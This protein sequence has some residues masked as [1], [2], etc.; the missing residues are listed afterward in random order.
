LRAGLSVIHCETLVI[1]FGLVS[2][3]AEDTGS[4]GDL[5]S[6]LPIRPTPPEPS[7]PVL[8]VA[9]IGRVDFGAEVD[10]R[11]VNAGP[12]LTGCV[13]S[14]VVSGAPRLALVGFGMTMVGGHKCV[15]SCI[16]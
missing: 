7:G 10:N 12:I 6:K 2:G 1:G 9:C 11:A 15:P 14:Q 8:T 4:T 16:M 13:E 5:A 3:L